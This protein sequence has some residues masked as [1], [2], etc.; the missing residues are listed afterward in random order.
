MLRIERSHLAEASAADI[1]TR[2]QA[3]RLWAFLA[4]RIAAAPAA[5]EHGPRF[6]FTNVLYYLGGMLAIGAMSL[7]MTLG[8]DAFGGWGVFFIALLYMGAALAL[9]RRFERQDLAIPMGIMA[10][11]VVVL[12]PLA[13]WGLQHALGF[14]ADA[15][16]A[17]HY[18]QYHYVIDWRWVTL[19]FATLLAGVL[20]LYRWKAPFLL[21]PVSVTLWYMSM[22]LALLLLPPD[23][24]PWSESEWL[25][26]K[27]FS[28]A[29][30]LVMVLVAFWVDLRSRFTKD[31]A[32]WLYLFGLL[33]FWGGLSS[34]GSNQLAGKL[35][36]L[37]I[38]LGLVLIGA[39][40]VRRAFTVFGGI[41]VAIVLA[42]I[43]WRFFKDSWL[44]PIALTAIGLAVVYLGIWWSRNEARL[45]GTLQARLPADLRELIASRRASLGH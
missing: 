19:E 18:R 15:K 3:D 30:G 31:Y 38:N 39:V 41:G 26:R 37:A 1:I 6:T 32:F 17:E 16:G 42:D 9:A 2:E 23:V 12:V 34:L 5:R 36:Y 21:M 45:A 27:W 7:F 22:D 40:L 43:S 44:F 33:A 11:L 8:W 13:V 4:E 10:A 20:M 35:V 29:F 28:V 25:F 24:K 14:W